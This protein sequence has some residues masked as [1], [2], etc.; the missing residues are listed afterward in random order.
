MHTK[1]QKWGNS[2]GIRLPKSVLDFM[3]L[4]VDDKVEIIQRENDIV[5]RKVDESV[6]LESI[7]EG[8]KGDVPEKYD[9]GAPL[10]VEIW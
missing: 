5:L 10:G 7:F 1:I 9:W 3:G 2:Q 6:T 4:S 8:Y